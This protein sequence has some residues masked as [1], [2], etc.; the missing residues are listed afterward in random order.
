LD[1][2]VVRIPHPRPGRVAVGAVTTT[3]VSVVPVFLVGGLAFQISSELD[4][5]PA[6]LGLAVSV[7]FGVTALASVPV[8]RLVEHRGA[9]LASRAAILLSAAGM[10]AIAVLVRSLA[11]LLVLLGTTAL[12]NALGQLSSNAALARAVPTRRQGLTFGAKQASIPLSTLL[13][14]AAVPAVALT[15]GWRWA[16]VIMAAAAV[17]ALFAVPRDE[18]TTRAAA[19]HRGRAPADLVVLGL[20][21]TL[22]AGAANAMATFL[23]DSSVARGIHPGLAGLLLTFGSAVCVAMR[24]AV[25]WLADRRGRGQLAG[26]A[27]LLLTC[28]IGL[29]L[30][31]QRSL[32]ALAG[33]VV[34]G[35]GIGWAWPGLLAFAVVRLHPQAPAAATSVTQTGVYAGAGIGPLALGWVA[36]HFG[37]GR[38]W[39]VAGMCA[40]L[41]AAL[42]LLGARLGSAGAIGDEV[43]EGLEGVPGRNVGQPDE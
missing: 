22:A 31:S 43:A 12:A 10:L 8:G 14:G 18:S 42:V 11:V 19:A 32:V 30:L 35:L 17:G 23:V 4:L 20:A 3:V 15:I 28:G 16:F 25:G 26:V 6:D 39:P 27:A 7:Y 5:T 1:S 21:A 38:M 37:Y 41:A 40:L 33:G 13:A 9:A 34:L 2:T 29:L 36:T 24:L